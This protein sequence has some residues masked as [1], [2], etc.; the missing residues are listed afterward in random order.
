MT[1]EA[2]LFFVFFI[3]SDFQL[4]SKVIFA[5][6]IELEARWQQ[7]KLLNTLVYRHSNNFALFFRS[8]TGL[9]KQ[10]LLCPHN[11]VASSMYVN[12]QSRT[13]LKVVVKSIRKLLTCDCK[14]FC[15]LSASL[16]FRPDFGSYFSSF[17]VLKQ[18]LLVPSTLYLTASSCKKLQR[19]KTAILN[20][21]QQRI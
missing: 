9:S 10:P 6:E 18:S 1:S 21:E 20:S 5:Q 4:S 19:E 2:T 8:K 14:Y 17:L 11:L 13:I 7:K 15:I 16:K 12:T 3:A